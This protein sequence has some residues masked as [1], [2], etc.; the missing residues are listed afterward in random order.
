[1]NIIVRADLLWKPYEREL[2]NAVSAKSITTRSDRATRALAHM[3]PCLATEN[4]S[5]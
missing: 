2:H 3:A 5:K 4:Q 1:M